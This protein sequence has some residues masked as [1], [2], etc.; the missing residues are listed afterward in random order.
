M[1]SRLGRRTSSSS[2][3]APRSSARPS[4]AVEVAP[5]ARRSRSRPGCRRAR[6]G[7]ASAGADLLDAEAAVEGEAD[8]SAPPEALA[9][10]LGAA[11]GDDAALAQDRHAV[12]EVLGL[13]HVVGGEEDRLA[14][15]LEALDHVPGVAPGGRVE[16]GGRLVEEDQ[17]GVAD[18]PD[19]DVGAAFLAAGEG[20]DAGVAFVAEA[21]QL[22]RLVDRP[23]RLVEAGEEG[24]RLVHG[25]ER[26]EL[27]LLQDQAD[28]VAPGAGRLRRGRRRAPRPRRRCA[29]GSPRGSRSSSSCRRRWGR[30]SRR[31]RRRRPRSR[32]R[33]RLRA[34]RRTCAG[35]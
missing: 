6:P 7:A 5:A 15:R 28:A 32:F 26:V 3:S 31:P 9:E 27:A 35:R 12:G 10:L 19:R 18:D 34:R 30:G 25:P 17:V 22:D 11:L 21:D 24:D 2:S 29:R 13:V 1:S 23:R 33:G 4:S 8:H 14:E 20:A 16:A